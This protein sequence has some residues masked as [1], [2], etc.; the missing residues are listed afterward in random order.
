MASSLT[1]GLVRVLDAD[2]STA[3]AGFVV[4]D[5][6]L[7][8]TCAHVVECAGV[9]PRGT[10]RV[11]FVVTGETA[12]TTIEHSSWRPAAA[13]DVAILRVSGRLPP[14][15][16]P[17]PLGSARGAETHPFSTYGFPDG[18][19][20]EG[21]A[22]NGTISGLIPTR[23]AGTVLQLTGITEATSGFSGAPIL[24]TVTDRV[25]GMVTRITAPDQYGRLTQT[26]F[27]TPADVIRR[28]C[29]T[30]RLSDACPF[31]SLAAFTEA[32][33][34]VFFGRQRLTERLLESLRRQ[35]RFLTVLGPSG[36]GKSSLIQ[37]GLIPR[38]RHA[39]L[40]GS[41]RWEILT[42]RQYDRPQERLG[43]TGEL[44]S[45]DGLSQEVE[46]RLSRHPEIPRLVL[47]LDQFEEALGHPALVSQ[48]AS[49]L[50]SPRE[51]AVI[52]IM[53]NDF[54]SRFADQA[55]ALVPWLEQC[56]LFN[57]PRFLDRDEI[58]AMVTEPA[59]VA[60]LR[61]EPGLVDD[62]VDDAM[63]G[64]TAGAEGI[65][66]ARSTVLP[67][68][69]F[70]LTELWERRQDGTLTH[71][72]YEKIGRVTGSLAQ[73]ADHAYYTLDESL[74]EIARHIFTG[75]VRLG[76]E[77][78]GVPDTGRRRSLASFY[79]TLQPAV[80]DQVVGHLAAARLVTTGCD[81]SGQET[82]E[83]IHEALLREWSLVRQWLKEDRAFL[84][85]C[86]EL[87]ARVRSWTETE[88]RDVDQ[89]LRGQELA[90]AEEWLARRAPDITL[91]A[92]NFIEASAAWHELE[93]LSEKA[94]IQH[95]WEATQKVARAE[96]M[97]TQGENGHRRAWLALGLTVVAAML[98]PL[99]LH[100]LPFFAGL[101]LSGY[102]FFLQHRTQHPAVSKIVIVYADQTTVDGLDG[103]SSQGTAAG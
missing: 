91:S 21:I 52:L 28:V 26:A 77:S 30:L 5:E 53:R 46:R 32:D 16:T 88:R 35:S 83:L 15:I 76:D 18:T 14:G 9:S 2:G 69:E 31:R 36:S 99:A 89:L 7:I 101:E 1:P 19:F 75:L 100:A 56:P 71:E 72:A 94:R 66:G 22:G 103:P 96:Q 42:I 98:F 47:I 29:P 34:P 33:A 24:D 67:L 85:W 86:Q 49:L 23:E 97:L 59:R 95:D 70:T 87:D 81:E 41:D 13:E 78:Q 93:V 54:Y 60:G 84:T 90:V 58:A 92:R 37:A 80:V 82:V 45:G 40:P 63:E 27:G 3:G 73:W 17:L 102:D 10:V 8:A 61:F 44:G 6:G 50:K 74:R 55:P 12:E 68:L 11:L 39:G 4:G 57:V 43:D 38:L 64:D 25:V 51:I 79:S 48:L 65:R 20:E 62:I